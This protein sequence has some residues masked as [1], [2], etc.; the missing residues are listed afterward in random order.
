MSALS[1]WI[2]EQRKSLGLTQAQFAS[3]IGIHQAQVSGVESGRIVPDDIT[4]EKINSVLGKFPGLFT[5]NKMTALPK[6]IMSD[7][8][9]E[10]LEAY[11]EARENNFYLSID[12]NT[13][14][15]ADRNQYILKQGA[16]TSYF[17][18]IKALLKF[19]VA[20]RMK[21]SSIDSVQ[22]ISDKLDETYALIEAKF[23][24]LNPANISDTVDLD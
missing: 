6:K 24:G 2:K 12:D 21:Q 11:R 15:T 10:G 16:N 23:A 20:T 14:I 4:M 8:A 13:H 5:P 3:K 7:K 17:V 9:K 22:Q 19:L 18:E 1:D